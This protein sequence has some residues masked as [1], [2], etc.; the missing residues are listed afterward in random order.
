MDLTGITSNALAPAA[1]KV[2]AGNGTNVITGAESLINTITGG[3]GVDTITGG[4]GADVLGG[5]NGNDVIN[6]GGGT[7]TITGGAGADTVTGG[8]GVD[9]SVLADTDSNATGAAV[10]IATS[11]IDT[12]N[13]TTGDKFNFDGTSALNTD[14]GVDIAIALDDDDDDTTFTELLAAMDAAVNADTADLDAI[15]FNVTDTGSGGS[16]SLAGFYIVAA[17]DGTVSDNDVII[18]ILGT[19]LDGNSTITIDTGLVVINI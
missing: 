9:T 11:G 2:A 3:T 19:G 6:G 18:H 15:L 12:Y 16:N 5:G 10:S 7:D 17:L 8:T 1:I 13:V 4:D 14:A